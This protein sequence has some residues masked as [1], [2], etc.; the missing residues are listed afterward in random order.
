MCESPF[1][2]LH[3]TIQFTVICGEP[4]K[5]SHWSLHL[6]DSATDVREHKGVKPNDFVVVV[7]VLF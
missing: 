4:E 3:R 6:H 7:V 5:K 2:C 1:T